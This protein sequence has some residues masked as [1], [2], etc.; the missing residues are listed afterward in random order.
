[1]RHL[2]FAFCLLLIGLGPGCTSR[3]GCTDGAAANYD[4]KSRIEDSSCV[5]PS[6]AITITPWVDLKSK[7]SESSGVLCWAGR[8]WTFND[9]GNAPEIYS[10]DTSDG[11]TLETITLGQVIN[12]DFEDIAQDTGYVYVGDIGNNN[13][14]RTDL[15]VYRVKKGDASQIKKTDTKDVSSIYYSYS[16]QTDFRKDP[17][18]SFDCEAM[19]WYEG[20]LYLFSKD[21][22]R[23]ITTCY[24]LNS[25]PGTQ[26]A[27]PQGAFNTGGVVTGADISPNGKYLVLTGFHPTT[28]KAFLWIL[29][30]WKDNHFFT[31]KKKLIE[32]G[33][34]KDVGQIEGIGFWDDQTLILSNELFGQ[35]DPRLYRLNLTNLIF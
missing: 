9:G 18:N 23:L 7:F 31:G 5:Y 33:Y 24:S 28:D 15:V 20:Q 27:I 17:V 19:I 2:Y 11:S 8:V 13:G 21:H 10:I 14:N 32:L 22:K 1:M 12:V 25:T 34:R 16:D 35:V 4:I 29:S 26:Q 30:D 3:K 6:K